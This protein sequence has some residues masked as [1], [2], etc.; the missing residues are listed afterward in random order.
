MNN[1]FYVYVYLDYRKPDTY[2]YGE[3]HFKYEPFY[4]GKGKDDRM[5]KHLQ[6]YDDT[7]KTRKLKKIL[8]TIS[9]EE[10]KSQ[11]IILQK[12]SL[13]ECQALMLEQDMIQTIGRRDLK[14]GPLTN[15]TDGGDGISGYIWTDNQR[16]NASKGALNRLPDSEKT[17]KI[18]SLSKRKF[19]NDGGKPWNY[20]IPTSIE[21]RKRQSTIRKKFYQ[22]GGIHPLKDKKR[23]DKVWNKDRKN[24]F[25]WIFIYKNNEIKRKQI[26]KEKLVYYLSDGWIK[27]FGKR[28][29]QTW[30]K[31]RKNELIWIYNKKTKLT[32]MINK[33][34]TIPKDWER[35]RKFF[36][37]ER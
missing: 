10:F 27:G 1:Q 28:K 16:K 36:N 5:Y 37:K 29:N 34:F 19:F 14:L 7:F 23:K 30:N 32:K 22:N 6:L 11:Y 25:I 8:K 9:T 31:D 26:K 33:N 2:N 21:T 24:E 35:G 3:Y 18:K 12:F 13:L 17:K 20:N 4:V 15:L